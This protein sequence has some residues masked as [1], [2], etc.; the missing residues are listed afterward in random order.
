MRAEQI[1]EATKM[2]K[3]G[4]IDEKAFLNRVTFHE[5]CICDG[6]L[7]FDS[8]PDQAEDEQEEEVD[9]ADVD[10]EVTEPPLDDKICKTCFEKPQDCCFAP[11]GHSYFCNDC[12]QLKYDQTRGCPVCRAD[13]VYAIKIRH[14]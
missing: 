14:C 12:F 7:D 6:F 1:E 5:N 10:S 13:I 11:C 4:E 3:K 2:L 9:I 8:I